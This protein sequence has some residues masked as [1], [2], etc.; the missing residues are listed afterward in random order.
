[1][2]R[3]SAFRV[4]GQGCGTAA[5]Y[6]GPHMIG[7]HAGVVTR[8]QGGGFV[9]DE[10]QQFW[11]RFLCAFDCVSLSPGWRLAGVTAVDVQ[12]GNCC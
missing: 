8:R 4:A 11:M 10:L 5:Q 3:R 6:A 7:K 1:M 12:G 9:G 2:T